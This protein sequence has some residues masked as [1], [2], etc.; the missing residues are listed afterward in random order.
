M[1]MNGNRIEENRAMRHIDRLFQFQVQLIASLASSIVFQSLSQWLS[2]SFCLNLGS[3]LNS[4]VRL[5]F[6]GNLLDFISWS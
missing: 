2:D 1:I 4:T 5:F 3:I 6:D